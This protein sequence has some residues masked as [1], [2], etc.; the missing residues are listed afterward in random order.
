MKKRWLIVLLCG[1][2]AAPAAAQTVGLQDC[3]ERGLK[4]NYSVRI[5]RGEEQKAR[6]NAT[7]GNAGYLPTLDL[8]GGYS[9]NVN[10]NRNRMAADGAIEK[11]NGVSSQSLDAGVTL[12]WT[13]F[14]GLNIQ[15]EYA[16]LK[17]LRMMGELNT[18]LAVEDLAAEIASEY[19]NLIRQKTRLRNLRATLDL[20]RERL[21][22]VEAE[23]NIGSMSR[24]DLQ[25]AQVDFNADS[26]TVIN[27]LEVLHASHIRLNQ[28]MA[29][30]DVESPLPIRDSTIHPDPSLDRTDLW[31]STL[32]SNVSLLM[33]QK[34]LQISQLDLKKARSRNYPYVRLNAGYGYNATWNG[35]GTIDLGQRLGLNYGVTVG[36]NLFDGMNRR[37]EQRNARIDIDNQQ[38]QIEDT[39]LALQSDMSNLWMAYQNN[40]DLWELEKQNVVA[41]QDYY[42]IA[43]DRYKLHELSGIELARGAKQPAGGRGTPL[44]CGVFDQ[45]LRDFPA[46]AQRA[47]AAPDISQ[48]G[49]CRCGDFSGTINPFSSADAGKRKA[50][51][52]CPPAFRLPASRGFPQRIRTRRCPRYTMTNPTTRLTT[53]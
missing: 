3:I 45:D 12:N 13:V 46:A 2:A 51:G 19:Y 14:D 32:S 47:A 29:A 49:D 21:R 24:L 15:A 43:I 5:V 40:L 53:A 1:A 38:L 20:S 48:R 52:Q 25:Q 27:Q 35:S 44:D 34:N 7:I 6:N 39:R 31:S 10:D 36:L 23:Y 16:R 30:E 22:I 37:R 28:L 41:A 26:S 42:S 4:N 33:A 50:G 8:S 9:G 18:R 17:E 11:T